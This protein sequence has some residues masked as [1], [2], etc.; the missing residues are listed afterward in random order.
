MPELTADGK[1]SV[2]TLAE[3]YAISEDAISTLIEALI[4]GRGTAAQFNHPDL[5]GMGQWVQGGMIMIGDMFNND[6]K[7]RVG[8][9]CTELAKLL[10]EGQLIET[11]DAH[12]TSATTAGATNSSYESS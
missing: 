4:S 12:K 5:G 8:S 10:S 6:L 9:L 1:E 3:K 2:K 11:Q 7:H